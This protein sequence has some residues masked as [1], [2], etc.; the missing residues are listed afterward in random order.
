MGHGTPF[1]HQL[2]ADRRV[3]LPFNEWQQRQ[4]KMHRDIKG[5]HIMPPTGGV[6]LTKFTESSFSLYLP[7]KTSFISDFTCYCNHDSTMFSPTFHP[8][9]PNG[10]PPFAVVPA[11]PLP[12]PRGSK[13]ARQGKTQRAWPPEGFLRNWVTPMTD[14]SDM[15]RYVQNMRMYQR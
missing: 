14:G 5:H 8:K 2:F 4:L 6:Y 1:L 15:F 7:H 13:G 9:G 10:E 11:A 3:V 12:C